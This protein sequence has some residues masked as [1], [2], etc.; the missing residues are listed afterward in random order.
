[1][2]S[3]TTKESSAASAVIIP[4]TRG[5]LISYLLHRLARAAALSAT[6]VPPAGGAQRRG[7]G[8]CGRLTY[9]PNGSGQNT[10]EKITYRGRAQGGAQIGASARRRD[11]RR[12]RP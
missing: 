1:M 2:Q 3:R 9:E 10:S 4:I 12:A 6:L 11:H 5:L 7:K 8:G